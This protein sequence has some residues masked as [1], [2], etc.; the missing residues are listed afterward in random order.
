MYGGTGTE[1]C[2]GAG[3]PA[4]GRRCRAYRHE[5]QS[6]TTRLK[7]KEPGSASHIQ[8]TSSHP[9]KASAEDNTYA[10]REREPGTDTQ[11]GGDRPARGILTKTHGQTA[12]QQIRGPI[13][14]WGLSAAGSSATA[15]AVPIGLRA[16]PRGHLPEHTRRPSRSVGSTGRSLQEPGASRD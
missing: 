15:W 2:R 6:G 8:S 3:S 7:T 10:R 12:R 13:R 1:R 9:F 14:N 5:R 4:H 16:P 11:G